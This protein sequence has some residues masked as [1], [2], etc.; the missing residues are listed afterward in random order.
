MEM[1]PL[2]VCFPSEVC[3]YF[4]PQKSMKGFYGRSTKVQFLNYNLAV[5]YTVGFF[6]FLLPGN[7]FWSC[8]LN[9]P[10]RRRRKE[11]ND[12]SVN[13]RR[14]MKLYSL[15]RILGSFILPGSAHIYIICLSACNE[16]SSVLDREK[17]LY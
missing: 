15:R 17:Y 14:I 6:S 7:E 4:T 1:V 3:I 8:Q 10:K 2:F 11:R 12:C 5:K 13:L 16:L 9:P